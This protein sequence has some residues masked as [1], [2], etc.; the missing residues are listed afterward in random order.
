MA[1]SDE[2]A[3]TPKHARGSVKVQRGRKI[4]FLTFSEE[5]SFP[6]DYDYT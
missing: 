2:D 4:P 6:E 3:H 5:R 1:S